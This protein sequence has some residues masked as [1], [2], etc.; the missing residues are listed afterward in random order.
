M[1]QESSAAGSPDRTLALAR[2]VL[3]I[4]AEAV[5]AIADRLGGWYTPASVAVGLI[6]FCPVYVP[7]GIS[8]RKRGS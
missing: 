3:R 7:F 6:G 8:T 2:R 1:A 4:E 5:S